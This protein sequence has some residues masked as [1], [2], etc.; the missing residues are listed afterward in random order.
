GNRSPAPGGY[1]SHYEAGDL[2]GLASLG[3]AKGCLTKYRGRYQPRAGGPVLT[4]G[5]VSPG[6]EVVDLVEEH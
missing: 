2:T 6:R 3:A 1:F 4:P 5:V